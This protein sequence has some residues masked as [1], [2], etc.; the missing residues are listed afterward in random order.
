MRILLDTQVFLWMHVSSA[1]MSS[2]ARATLRDGANTLLF[3]AVSSW[4]IA[5]KYALGRLSL[6]DLPSR[7]VTDRIRTSGLTPVA[8]EHVHALRVEGLPLHH[9]DPFD[10]LLVAQAMELGV[11][12]MTADSAF[13]SYEIEVFP[14]TGRLPRPRRVLQNG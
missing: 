9:R 4:E 8:I 6:P 14:A 5:I 12:I 7:Y 2:T 10:R 3:S 11:P 13:A 1:R